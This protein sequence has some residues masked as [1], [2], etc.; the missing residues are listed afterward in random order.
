MRRLLAPGLWALFALALAAPAAA[1][2]AAPGELI[3]RFRASADAADRVETLAHRRA[4]VRRG[5]GLRGLTL[6]RLQRGDSLTAAAAA[7]ERDPDVLYAEPNHIHKIQ[8]TPNDPRYSS[9][10]GLAAIAAP[11]AWDTTTG[12]AGVSVAIVDTGVATGHPDLAPNIWTN[13]DETPNGVDDDGNGKVDDLN[14][15]DF[16]DGD[17]TAQDGYGHGTHVAGT[18]GARGND[19]VGIAGVA[20]QTKLM[21]LRAAD[22]DGFLFSTDIVAAFN[23]A[24]GEGARIVNGSF[25]GSGST[26]IRDAIDACPGALFVFSAGNEAVDVDWEPTYPCAYPSANIVCVA[27]T[28]EDDELAWFSN[29][30][31]HGV[32]LGAPGEAIL[33]SVPPNAYEE[34]DGTSMAAP[35]VSGAAALVAAHRP[36][37][38]AVQLRAA[39]LN[40][41][42][43]VAAI[44]ELVG[45]GGRLNVS[46]ALTSSTVP[47]A[48]RPPLPPP[49]PPPAPPP[50]PPPPAA[51]AD[52]TAP[53][54]P[55]VGSTSHVVG[56]RSIDATV[57][58]SWS[59][60]FDFG[61]GIDGYSFS[62]DT[63]S[64]SMPDTVKDS[65]E[66]AANTISAPLAPGSYW[67]HLRTRDNAGNWSGG[68]HAGPYVITHA[69]IP[70]PQRCTVPR[71]RGKTL[72][73][74]AGVLKRAGCK[75]GPVK[76]VRSR[77]RKGR[78]VAQRPPAGRKVGKGTP[79]VVTISRGK[80]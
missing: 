45:Q 8:L 5:L 44:A 9:L 39:L 52:V 12:S 6:V 71:V 73:T 42:D 63:L 77:V 80:R 25:G 32:D 38:T 47:P 3:V 2:D 78:I 66:T 51:P 13:P 56:V 68:A 46:R 33:S 28:T 1:Q 72:R 57:E 41:V 27:A 48:E 30:G 26:A 22:D 40:A 54:D 69:A 21:P 11:V 43:P 75:L 67:F 53:T 19:G 60:A 29:Y 14:G 62:W 76:R 23:Y 58:V 55:A 4:T 10:W 17:P 64:S 16:V 50:A 20:W 24:C 65:E 61:S 35:H 36:T 74:A 31:R 37:L 59:G 70:Q 79:V 34:H 15:W 49:P 7:L 18:I